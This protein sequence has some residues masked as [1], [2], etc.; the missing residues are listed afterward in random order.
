MVKEGIISVKGNASSKKF[1]T[2]P[3]APNLPPNDFKNINPDMGAPITSLN[4][5][6]HG[7]TKLKQPIK[8]IAI[9][10]DKEGIMVVC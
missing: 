3:T 5:P 9:Q 8:S 4:S 6:M 7:I 10:N 2:A 1:N